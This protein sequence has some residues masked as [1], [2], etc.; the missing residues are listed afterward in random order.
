MGLDYLLTVAAFVLFVLSAANV[1]SPRV[2]LLAAW[3]AC[4]TLTL[5]V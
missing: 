3:L 1:N 2:G 5:L 4:L